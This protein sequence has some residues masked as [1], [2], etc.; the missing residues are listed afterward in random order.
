M[1][2]THRTI[3]N[4]SELNADVNLLLKQGFPLLWVEGEI[5]NFSCP[6]SGHF[7]FSLKDSSAQIRCAMFK[8]RNRHLD[9]TAKN[10]VKVLV[11]GRVG[12]YEARG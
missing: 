3:L 10:G 8:N 6:A 12:L 4:V 11:R 9:L 1:Q 5:S 2:N 7:Y